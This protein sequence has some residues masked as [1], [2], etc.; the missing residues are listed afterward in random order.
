M[1]AKTLTY[2]LVV[3]A[4]APLCRT[5][6]LSEAGGVHFEVASVKQ[7]TT[8]EIGGVHTYP[9]GRVAFRGCTPAYLI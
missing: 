9:G 8:G 1:Q 7:A 5:Q 4:G 3:C 2:L 6:Q